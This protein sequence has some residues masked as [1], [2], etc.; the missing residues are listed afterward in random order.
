[1]AI[2]CIGVS[3]V[4]HWRPAAD[5]ESYMQKCGRAGRNGQPS[6]A[7]LY[8]KKSD[9]RHETSKE[10][11]KYCK[12]DSCR[13]TLMCSYFDCVA[14]QVVGCVCRDLC[15]RSCTQYKLHNENCKL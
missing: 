6:S 5:L 1:M 11:I 15:S 7:I 14:A 2:D 8:W 3:Q 10:M 12:E 13:R 9:L 4:I